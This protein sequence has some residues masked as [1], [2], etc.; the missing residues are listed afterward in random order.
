MAGIF[1]TLR[2]ALTAK[3]TTA[4]DLEAAVAEAASVLQRAEATL[5][6][7]RESRRE[8]LAADDAGRTRLRLATRE[9]EDDVADARDYLAALG[10]R[11]REA[12]EA[13]AEAARVARYRDAQARQSAAAKAFG[14]AY[15][16]AAG[17]LA[18]LVHSTAEV[19]AAVAAANADLPSGAEP[20][21]TVEGAV[22]DLPGRQ[23][24]EF[25][26]T[27]REA[28]A[29]FGL[30]QI[31][32]PAA[33]ERVEDY[34]DGTGVV[35][36]GLTKHKVERRRI[37]ETAWLDAEPGCTGPRVADLCL[38]GLKAADAPFRG[39]APIT[40]TVPPIGERIERSS[41]TILP[42][43]PVETEQAAA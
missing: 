12:V 25:A 23:R 34:G 30:D 9:A 36:I 11:H 16:K 15:T 40:W 21:R 17:E 18:K 4:N 8:G 42:R 13:E 2:R 20:L 1:D 35:T 22:R 14:P 33:Q 24:V 3:S 28:W 38:P 27:E 26:P 39:P 37:R 7:L 6:E 10:D 5:A 29:Y 32:P 19:D 41:Y 31:I 43:E